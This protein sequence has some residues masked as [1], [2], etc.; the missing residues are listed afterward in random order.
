MFPIKN[1]ISLVARLSIWYIYAFHICLEHSKEECDSNVLGFC[2]HSAHVYLIIFIFHWN[3]LAGICSPEGG[4]CRFE[5]YFFCY[6]VLLRC[7]F[8]R[9]EDSLEVSLCSL[10]CEGL[11][12]YGPISYNSTLFWRA[13]W[14]PLITSCDV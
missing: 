13:V 8:Q 11:V 2:S 12:R 5:P 7:T 9:G 10:G 14:C 6:E 4:L 3:Q 1:D